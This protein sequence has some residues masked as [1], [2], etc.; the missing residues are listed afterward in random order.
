RLKVAVINQTYL[1]VNTPLSCV[2]HKEVLSVQKY[3]QA[4]AKLVHINESAFARANGTLV[5]DP[6]NG[7]IGTNIADARDKITFAGNADD[8]GRLGLHHL[9]ASLGPCGRHIEIASI[10]RGQR[11]DLLSSFAVEAAGR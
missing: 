4:R 7:K 5:R 2:R 11:A 9:L 8:G 10:L 3:V 6:E 1:H